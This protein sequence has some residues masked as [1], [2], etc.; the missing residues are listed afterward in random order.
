[1]KK[2]RAFAWSILLLSAMASC[3]KKSNTQGRYIPEDAGVAVIVNGKTLCEKLPWELVRQNSTLAEVLKDSSV[4]AEVRKLLEE[5]E[6]TGIDIHE[7]FAFFLIKDSLNS[8]VCMSGKVKDEAAFRKTGEQLTGSPA[9]AGG[10]A[11]TFIMKDRI[12][13]G[14]DKKEFI[15]AVHTPEL[16]ETYRSNLMSPDTSEVIKAKFTP[17][18]NAQSV[19]RQLFELPEVASMAK[20][21]KFSK[22]MEEPGDIHFW[23]NNEVMSRNKGMDAAAMLFNLDKLYEGSIATSTVQ[24]ENG[25]IKINN[26]SYSGPDMTKIFKRY[27]GSHVNEDLVKSIPGKEVQGVLAISFNPKALLELMKLFG[28]DGYMNIATSRLGFKVDDFI[29]ANKGDILFAVSDLQNKPDTAVTNLGEGSMT[30]I[31]RA[32]GNYFFATTIADKDA[33]HKMTD[34]LRKMMS[35]GLGGMNEGVV[36]ASNEKMFVMSNGGANTENFLKGAIQSPDFLPSISGAPIGGFLNLH[37]VVSA[38][39]P[40]ANADSSDKALHTLML[41]MWDKISLKGGAMDDD[42]MTQEIVIGLLN[43]QENSLKQLNRF[44]S[45]LSKIKKELDRKREALMHS[46]DDMP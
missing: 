31:S 38:M 19:C 25:S 24:F 22:L 33:F 39:Q 42:A 9:P 20:S 13:I 44:S 6:K 45:E 11:R 35:S 16:S 43:K 21:A 12:S 34:G 17:V 4:T 26:H 7:D 3:G 32:K 30:S 1:M 5:P 40:D 14:W 37:S 46:F 18:D 2:L 28:L 29:K 10:N 8:Y 15:L 27:S 23:L 41:N 36:T